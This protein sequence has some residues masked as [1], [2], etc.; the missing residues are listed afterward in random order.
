MDDEFIL[1][2]D[3]IYYRGRVLRWA[4]LATALLLIFIPRLELLWRTRRGGYADSSSSEKPRHDMT[5]FLGFAAYVCINGVA[6]RMV[7][8]KALMGSDVYGI[9]T[10]LCAWLWAFVVFVNQMGVRRRPFSWPAI[11]C[12]IVL[13]GLVGRISGYVLGLHSAAIW[14]REIFL[15]SWLVFGLIGGCVAAG[16]GYPTVAGIILSPLLG[17]L[18][19]LVALFLPMRLSKREGN[20]AELEAAPASNQG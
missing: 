12:F 8:N 10:D 2:N 19:F 17:P 4:I 6:L 9:F 11:A 18:V 20:T 3:P 15:M 1:D 13:M 5:L 7:C 16:N 14:G